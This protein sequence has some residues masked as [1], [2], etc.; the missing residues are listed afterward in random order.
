MVDGGETV[1]VLEIDMFNVHDHDVACEHGGDHGGWGRG[2]PGH[3]QGDDSGGGMTKTLHYSE[4]RLAR[5]RIIDKSKE[6]R[7]QKDKKTWAD[8]SAPAAARRRIAEE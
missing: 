2:R 6:N 5:R 8:L 7:K 3:A 1:Q 4:S